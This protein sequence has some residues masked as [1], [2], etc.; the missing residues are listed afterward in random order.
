MR[1][2]VDR[3]GRVVL[4]RKSVT[5]TDTILLRLVNELPGLFE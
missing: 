3:F 4:P 5:A 1:T 2:R